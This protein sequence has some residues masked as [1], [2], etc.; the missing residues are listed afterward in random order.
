MNMKG[1]RKTIYVFWTGGYDSTF[2]II[3]L[4]LY[5]VFIQPIY[6][7]DNRLSEKNELQAISEITSLLKNRDET[8]ALFFDLIYVEKH[9]IK[10]NIDIT[11]SYL[12][13]WEKY[14]LGS[15]YDWLA[16]YAHE[17]NIKIE[18]GLEK[19]IKSHAYQVLFD[20]DLITR[21][22]LTGCEYKEL[23]Y[24][25]INIDKDIYTVFSNFLFPLP[26]FEMS[27]LEVL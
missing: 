2:R 16:R 21:E 14:K 18:L 15:Q 27:K 20:S 25:S 12:K 1:N 10:S 11:N 19:E 6:I 24:E 26:L 4:S 8:K 3:Q 23:S 22:H 5:K 9:S 13:L 17:H 7:S